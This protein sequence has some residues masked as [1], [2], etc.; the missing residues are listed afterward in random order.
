MENGPRGSGAPLGPTIRE[1]VRA[2]VS[3]ARQLRHTA[4]SLA[5]RIHAHNV[6]SVSE[7]L[8]ELVDEEALQK[9]LRDEREPVYHK[10]LNAWMEA[11]RGGE[12]PPSGPAPD[13]RRDQRA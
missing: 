13:A 5:S 9:E 2:Y 10:G 8:D 4:T 7:A 3:N 11:P 1:R 6:A 12:R